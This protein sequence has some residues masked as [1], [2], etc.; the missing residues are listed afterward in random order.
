MRSRGNILPHT[1]YYGK[2]PGVTY[3]STLGAAYKKAETEYGLRLAKRVLL[4]IKDMHLDM[5]IP[6]ELVESF[7]WSGDEV[8]NVCRED[9][10]QDS[11]ELLN[12]AFY[13]CLDDAGILLSSQTEIRPDVQDI[14]E[15]FKE[16]EL[17]SLPC[18]ISINDEDLDCDDPTTLYDNINDYM[19]YHYPN[20]GIEDND[21][22]EDVQEVGNPPPAHSDIDGTEV[23]NQVSLGSEKQESDATPPPSTSE[24]NTETEVR[25][26]PYTREVP[27]LDLH[28]GTDVLDSGA[29]G[30]IIGK[31]KAN[32]P[33]CDSVHNTPMEVEQ[34]Q[35]IGHD[36]EAMNEPREMETSQREG[37]HGDNDDDKE[38]CTNNELSLSSGATIPIYARVVEHDSTIY[39]DGYTIELPKTEDGFMTNLRGTVTDQ[40]FVEE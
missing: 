11:M 10:E 39:R 22:V 1:I 14:Y 28:H 24:H 5:V 38:E 15:D 7:I 34:F 4:Q 23:K 8:W 31:S 37:E 33:P 17:E 13:K 6:Q 18:D 9:S 3:S 35:E 19:D 29:Q 12:V 21:F 27:Q 36:L 25:E 2:P 26:W 20:D 32:T 40:P 30:D 16:N